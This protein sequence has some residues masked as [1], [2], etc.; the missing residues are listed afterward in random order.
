MY[1]FF[2]NCIIMTCMSTGKINILS[3]DI[4]NKIAAGEVIERPCSIVKELVENSIDAGATKIEISV[5]GNCRNIRISDNG[6]GISA[7]DADKVFLKH[8][9]SKISTENDLWNISTLGFRGEALASI[10]SVAKVTCLSATEDSE[11]GFRTVAENSV[12]TTSPAACSVGTIMIV[13]NLFENQ[14]AR[15]KFLKGDKTEFMYIKDYVKQAA[16]LNPATG[17]TLINDGN[18]I[19]STLPGRTLKNRIEEIYSDNISES[20]VPVEKEDAHFKMKLSGFV[21]LPSYTRSNRKD[22]YISVNSRAVKCPVFLK[23]IDTAYRNL[24]PAGKYPFCVLNLELPFSDIDVNV[25]PTKKEIR[26]LNPNPVFSFVIAGIEKALSSNNSVFSNKYF[27]KDNSDKNGYHAE[28]DFAKSDSAKFLSGKSADNVVKM[29]HARDNAVVSG[30]YDKSMPA[31]NIGMLI[32]DNLNSQSHDD[33]IGQYA[34]TYILIDTPDGLEIVDQHI[35]DERY[36]YEKLRA[37]KEI[38]SQII[39]IPQIVNLDCEKTE[40]LKEYHSELKKFGYEIDFISDTEAAFKKIPQILSK[41]N[42]E[43]IFSSLIENLGASDNSIEEKI[44]ITTA[45][46]A[47]VKA[48]EKLSIW[49]AEELIKRWRACE[50][51]EVCPHGRP[52]SKI[53][54]KKEIASFFARQIS[55]KETAYR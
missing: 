3:R 55:T 25:H 44:L 28:F 32:P 43:K 9:T 23:A 34:N 37:V 39:F 14:P 47:A 40:L 7:D 12:I 31:V 46:K 27:P 21:S 48:G 15:L 51:P 11:N 13:E 50:H 1:D 49:Q 54:S 33:I 42:H 35:A 26:Y 5:S 10:C 22:I 20:L 8:A 38:A 4:C 16:F 2:K 36:I 45:C 52:I 17:F 53:I 30:V 41:E 29:F 24:L 6:S 19:I 18:K